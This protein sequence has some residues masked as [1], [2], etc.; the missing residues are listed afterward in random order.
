MLNGLD[1]LHLISW[2]I[3]FVLFVWIAVVTWKLLTVSGAKRRLDEKLVA[4]DKAS[5][6]LINVINEINEISGRQDAVGKVLKI[7]RELISESISLVGLVRYDAFGDIG[8]EFSFS[9]AFLDESANGLVIT[10]INGR[11]EG[12]V[13]AKSVVAGKSTR[14]LSAEEEEAINKAVLSKSEGK[15]GSLVELEH[16]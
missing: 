2:G 8:G 4:A 3:L 11:N 15:R 9:A 7:H 12:R 5:D 13:Y 6:I 1:Q 10:S 14:P 16:H